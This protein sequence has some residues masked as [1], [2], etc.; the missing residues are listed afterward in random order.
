VDVI[1][2]LFNKYGQLIRGVSTHNDVVMS[3]WPVVFRTQWISD[4]QRQEV[5]AK[6][7]RGDFDP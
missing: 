5:A 7:E 4:E 1:F 3:I 6:I 2:G